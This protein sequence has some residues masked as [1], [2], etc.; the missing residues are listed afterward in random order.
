MLGLSCFKKRYFCIFFGTS[1]VI[2]F[3]LPV[4]GR[5]NFIV[6]VILNEKNI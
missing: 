5:K 2:A 4:L 1:I 6:I 3:I